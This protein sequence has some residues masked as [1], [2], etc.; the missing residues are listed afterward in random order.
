[1]NISKDNQV[2]CPHCRG[3]NFRLVASA[4]DVFGMVECSHCGYS[5]EGTTADDIK[6][7][8]GWSGNE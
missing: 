2:N 3:T 8:I 4:Y 6:S 5:V 1:M 7:A